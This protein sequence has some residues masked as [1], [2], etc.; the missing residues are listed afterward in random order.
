MLEKQIAAGTR[1]EITQDQRLDKLVIEAGGELVAPEGKS[2]VLMCNKELYDPRPGSY[3][4]DVLIRVIEAVDKLGE[5]EGPYRSGLFFDAGGLSEARSVLP[6]KA[7]ETQV[8]DLG[9]TLHGNFLNGITAAGGR[10]VVEDSTVSLLGNGDDFRLIGTA[11]AAAGDAEM[12]IRNS[13]IRSRGIAAT[14]VAVGGDADVLIDGCTLQGQG[15]EDPDYYLDNHHLTVVPWVLGLK[16][17]VRASNLLERG[18]VT[19]Y[20]ST[21]SCNGWGVL[22]VDA[23]KDATHNVV[24]VNASIPA[25]QAYDSGYCCYLLGG[26][27]ST[28]LGCTFDVPDYVF[29]VG[30]N[31][32]HSVVGPSSQANL[33]YRKQQLSL[34]DREIGLQNVPERPCIIRGGKFA[35]MWHHQSTGE[36]E[37]L[38]G[39]ELHAGIC[40]MLIKSGDRLNPPTIRCDGVTIDAP[41]LVH[42]M[43]SDDAGMGNFGRDKSWAP[44]FESVYAPVKD[45]T[46]DL[47]DPDAEG[48]VHVEFKNMQL[49]GDCFNT[50]W[51]KPQNL[52]LTLDHTALTGTISTGT[53]RHNGFS[54]GVAEDQQGNRICTDAQG[55]PYETKTVEDLLFGKMPVTY[56]LPETD[57]TGAPVYA[58]DT[59]PLPLIGYAISQSQPELL[60][61]VTVTAAAPINGGVIVTLKNG[62]VWTVTAPG[63]L[64]AL[65]IQEG[66]ELAGRLVL[67]G[68]Q[69]PAAPGSYQGVIQVF[70]V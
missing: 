12:V 8:Q 3:E 38:P 50:K 5:L 53:H 36:F 59:Q 2:L 23:T 43:E 45:E 28:F 49:S 34:L 30:G 32:H 51:G 61:D 37:I 68:R 4:G 27:T 6:G 35:G 13:T 67:N 16:G 25:G 15:I 26:T 40:A 20:N 11:V 60:G 39:T 33:Q 17:T 9:L 62:S 14:T 22:S 7:G 1:W 31:D 58:P 65:T 47:A 63:Y 41:M 24:N 42:L 18:T 66:S 46:W 55:R 57:E 19:Y 21:A 70:P 29:A 54:W 44:Y 48:A 69:I 56:H 10:V 52:A 64:T